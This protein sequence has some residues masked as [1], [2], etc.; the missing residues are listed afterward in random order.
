MIDFACGEGAGGII[1]SEL[2]CTYHGVDVAPSA[3]ERA[4]RSL[5]DYPGATVSILD[6]VN[7]PITGIY[8]AAVDIM[9][10]HMLIVDQDR[11]NYLHNAF[12]CLKENAPMLFFWQSYGMDARED[13]VESMAQWLS[14]TGADYVTPKIKTVSQNGLDIEVNLPYVPGR[15]RTKEGYAREM[16]DAGFVVENMVDMEANSQNPHSI[17]LFVRKSIAKDKA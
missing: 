13:K 11:E 14:I 15:A 6:M 1:L 16:K 10:L 8:D 9:G 4:K 17:S 7:G 12:N 2:G 3:I 5:K